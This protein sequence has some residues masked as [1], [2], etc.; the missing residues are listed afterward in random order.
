[1]VFFKK[2]KAS[3]LQ[4]AILVSTIVAV[5]LASFL[6]LTQTHRFFKTQS[7]FIFSVIDG[8]NNGITYSLQPK[9]S[10]KDSI[11]LENDALRTVIKKTIWGGFEKITA[12]ASVKTKTFSKTAIIGGTI[13]APFTSIFIADETLPLVLVGGTKIEGTAYISRKGIKPG[14]IA[15]HYFNGKELIDGNI[16]ISDGKLPKLS[17]QWIRDTRSLINHIPSNNDIVI[18]KEQLNTNSFFDKTQ[19]VYSDKELIV[20][21]SFT[22]NIIIKSE[23]SITVSANAKLADVTVV[24]PKII[25]ESGFRGNASFIATDNIKLENDVHLSYPSALVIMDNEIDPEKNVPLGEEPIYISENSFVKGIVVYLPK[26]IPETKQKTHVHIT[27]EPLA[28]IEGSV[29]SDGNTELYGTVLGT[30][31]TQRFITNKFGSKYINHIY[32]GKILGNDISPEFCGLPF[33][34]AKKGVVKWLY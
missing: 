23:D 26:K 14:V 7:Q 28:T 24:A 15:G 11:V 6:A 34:T 9:N 4:F 20:T 33:D 30:V 19:F 21:E 16:K 10:F 31:Y 27:V 8:A 13:S 18:G 1:M 29:Y 32:N 17:P 25:I 12:T 22:G 3:A 2:I 5:L